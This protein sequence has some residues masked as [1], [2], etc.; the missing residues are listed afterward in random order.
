MSIKGTSE[1]VNYLRH[2]AQKLMIMNVETLLERQLSG[3]PL[4][5]SYNNPA[6]QVLLPCHL[7]TRKLRLREAK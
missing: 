6:W 5:K 1:L 4:F 2:S 3:C 7:Q